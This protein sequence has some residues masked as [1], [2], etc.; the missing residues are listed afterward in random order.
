MSTEKSNRWWENYVVRYFVGTVFGAGIVVFLN[1][2]ESSPFH[3]FMSR[4]AGL[5]E[6]TFKDITVFASMGLAFC[7]VASSPVLTIHA[8]R[9]HTRVARV[10]ERIWCWTITLVLMAIIILVSATFAF[11]GKLSIAAF[12]TAFAVIGIQIVLITLA[13]LDRFSAVRE[14]Y[15][16]LSEARARNG[17][18]VREYVESYRHLR[19]HGNAFSIL[20]LE[21]I[22][23]FVMANL[24]TPETAAFVLVLW[25]LPASCS[26]VVASALE[27]R[28]VHDETLPK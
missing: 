6:G 28:L 15:F 18:S 14:F 13:A 7:Y 8:L 22:L 27:S 1:E 3:G 11:C 12:L 24:P 4:V 16:R 19:E 25:L 2:C 9:E 5:Q 21:A 20:V 23:G 26:W 17:E 10:K